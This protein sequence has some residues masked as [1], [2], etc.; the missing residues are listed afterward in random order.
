MN[1]DRGVIG[2]TSSLKDLK[3]KELRDLAK[4]FNIVGRWDMNKAEL[5]TAIE[6]AKF[7][8]KPVAH[9]D[10]VTKRTYLEY[11]NGEKR[12]VD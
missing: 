8:K 7:C 3:V 11:P 5:I 4:T 6:K 12:Y 1:I 9:Y 2:M 10:A